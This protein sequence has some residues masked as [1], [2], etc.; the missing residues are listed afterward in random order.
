VIRTLDDEA[1]SGRVS[2][3]LWYLYVLEEWIKAERA[4][5][6]ATPAPVLV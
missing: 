6:S 1:R 2:T 3:R 5:T 4:Q